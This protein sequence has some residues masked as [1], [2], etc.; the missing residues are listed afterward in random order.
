M[1]IKAFDS[2]LR[3][4]IVLGDQIETP[5]AGEPDISRMWI[6][7]GQFFSL[8]PDGMLEYAIIR[9]LLKT[10][11]WFARFSPEFVQQCV[12]TLL[13]SVFLGDEARVPE[14]FDDSS[15]S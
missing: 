4:I 5:F 2:I 14:A 12:R 9:D 1:D 7:A 8:R 11:G 13:E 6:T 10:P 3:R 15:T